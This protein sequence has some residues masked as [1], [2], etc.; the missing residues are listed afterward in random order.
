MKSL[1]LAGLGAAGITLAA[2]SLQAAPAGGLLAAVDRSAERVS[3]V[4]NVTWYG[5]RHCHWHY[6]YRYCHGYYPYR[7]WDYGY[8]RPHHRYGYYDHYGYWR[9][10]RYGH[11][12][13]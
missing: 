10:Y 12:W 2:T 1:V 9:P 13:Y 3:P 6:G 11:G 5:R 4:E 7:R 8:Y